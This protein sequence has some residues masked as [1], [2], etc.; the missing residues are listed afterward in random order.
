MAH[1]GGFVPR[2]RTIREENT[3]VAGKLDWE[4]LVQWSTVTAEKQARA[5]RRLRFWMQWNHDNAIRHLGERSRKWISENKRQ[6]ADKE[7]LGRAKRVQKAKAPVSVTTSAPV[8]VG[9]IP[10]VA[11]VAPVTN[12][13]SGSPIDT[14]L[15]PYTSEDDDDDDDDDMVV[16]EEDPELQALLASLS[17]GNM[18]AAA[19]PATTPALF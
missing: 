4:N 16:E 2:W 13:V 19:N 8:P 11:P 10:L 18:S 5:I 6:T 3:L 17:S 15:F 14:P 1:S 7:T 9:A 12:P